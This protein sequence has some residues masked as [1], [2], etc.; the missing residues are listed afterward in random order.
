ME[1]NSYAVYAKYIIFSLLRT[2][3]T[4][5]CTIYPDLHTSPHFWYQMSWERCR[6]V[7]EKPGSNMW[8]IITKFE[9]IKLTSSTLKIFFFKN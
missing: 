6:K 7:T 3:A 5:K 4:Y 2:Q 8:F 1:M 9:R